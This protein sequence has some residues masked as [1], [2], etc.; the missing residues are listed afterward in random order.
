MRRR[1]QRGGHSARRI[2]F[3]YGHSANCNFTRNSRR[4]RIMLMR[5]SPRNCN[6][7]IFLLWV[8]SSTLLRFTNKPKPLT[9]ATEA[10]NDSLEEKMDN[11]PRQ[12]PTQTTFWDFVISICFKFN[13]FASF[14]EIRCQTISVLPCYACAVS[15]CAGKYRS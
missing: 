2:I 13:V 14:S 12:N 8:E 1:F 4:R 9:I 11:F 15:N 10:E 6:F 5:P 3:E 7:Y